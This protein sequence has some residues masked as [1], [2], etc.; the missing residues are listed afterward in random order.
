MKKLLHVLMC[1][2]LLFSAC[3]SDEEYEDVISAPGKKEMN[4]RFYGVKY[5]EGELNTKGVAQRKNLWYPGTTIKVKFLNSPDLSYVNKVKQYAAEW[6]EYADINFD[7][8]ESGDADVRVAFD[9]DSRYVTWS[10]TGTDCKKVVNQNEATVNFADWTYLSEEEMKGD[11]LRAFG[12]VLGLELEHRHLESGINW[13]RDM[14]AYWQNELGDIAWSELEKYVFDALD[15]NI[16]GNLIA[17]EVYDENSIMVWPFPRNYTNGISNYA[18]YELSGLDIELIKKIYPKEELGEI[19][20]SMETQEKYI[21]LNISHSEEIIIDWGDG[22]KEFLSSGTTKDYD[23]TFEGFERVIRIY[24]DKNAITELN[25]NGNGLR[26]L[27][28]FNNS[29]L[30]SLKCEENKLRGLNVYNN[31]KL[32]HLSCSKNE[33]EQLDIINNTSL[34]YLNCSE[35][36]LE[37]LV[38]WNNQILDTLICSKNNLSKLD[39]S[40]NSKLK[41]ID[42]S[43][44]D[45]L[46]SLDVT[47]NKVLSFLDCSF[48]YRLQQLDVSQNSNLENLNCKNN[49]IYYL[50]L[51]TNVNLRYL[52]CSENRE[53]Y[54]LFVGNSPALEELNY[55]FNKISSLDITANTLLKKLACSH[56]SISML[57]ISQNIHLQELD[58]KF[59]ELQS[60]DLSKNIALERIICFN[61]GLTSLDLSANTK[62][63]NLQCYWNPLI[64]DRSA[65]VSLA[66]SLPVISSGEGF[67]YIFNS[68]SA[69]WIQSICDSK[70]WHLW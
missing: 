9:W 60:L 64:S 12:Q 19:L 38:L 51:S 40:K 63:N 55:S 48:N 18:N 50:D 14:E 59:N 52:D 35:N 32:Q 41:A 26:E 22:N 1:F 67:I 31:T 62:L 45:A 68:D 53:M 6:T 39:I 17:T 36:K 23:H 49:D 16:S 11:V 56:N 28:V 21:H 43:Y 42:C 65:L 13:R 4:Y 20:V 27:N 61:N 5:P 33:I 34:L 10:Y 24:G 47:K 2:M 30:I 25:V 66:E 15:N 46:T 70:G 58:C 29:E 3:S 69:N 44:N 8:I 54:Y 57:N 7:F 37:N